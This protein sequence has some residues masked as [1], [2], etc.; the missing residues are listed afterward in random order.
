MKSDHALL[1]CFLIIIFVLYI[2]YAVKQ[3]ITNKEKGVKKEHWMDWAEDKYGVRN[4]T[5]ILKKE[6]FH[7][8]QY[9]FYKKIKI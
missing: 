9:Q 4:Q 7:C 3:R 2:Q 6:P 1:T 5:E 8:L